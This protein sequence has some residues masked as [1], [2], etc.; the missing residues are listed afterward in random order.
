M[1]L[2]MSSVVAVLAVLLSSAAV[3]PTRVQAQPPPVPPGPPAP[4]PKPPKPGPNQPVPRPGGVVTVTQV[5]G[6]NGIPTIMSTDIFLTTGGGGPIILPPATQAGFHYNYAYGSPSTHTFTVPAT[7]LDTATG[8]TVDV[9]DYHES[10]TLFAIGPSPANTSLTAYYFDPGNSQF[11]T[12]SVFAAV[13]EAL[14]LNVELPYPI[15]T[16]GT[17]APLYADIIANVYA[18]A[19]PVLSIG[20]TFSFVGGASAALPGVLL[21]TV[22]FT[23]DSTNGPSGDGFNGTVTVFGIDSLAA[24]P[25]PASLALLALGAAGALAASLRRRR[26]R[27][28]A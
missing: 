9:E 24:V 25:E 8:K 11:T 20:E 16:A 21:S 10:Q 5:P 3:S 2:R 13:Q 14:G 18:L 22:P 19:P 1:M 7:A 23:F 26:P 17:T 28:D 4:P 27:P 12:Y 15:L 6:A